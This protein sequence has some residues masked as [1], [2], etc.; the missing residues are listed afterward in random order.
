[1]DCT[2][3]KMTELSSQLMYVDAL[4]SLTQ[5]I[6]ALSV[7]CL[8]PLCPA[9]AFLRLS[10][11]SFCRIQSRDSYKQTLWWQKPTGGSTLSLLQTFPLTELG[12]SE[13]HKRWL[14]T[15]S[16]HAAATS[17]PAGA[18]A[19][20][21]TAPCT[22]QKLST[23]LCCGWRQRKSQHRD[24][25]LQGSGKFCN[26]IVWDIPSVWITDSKRTCVR[27]ELKKSA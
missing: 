5:A 6:A 23:A 15:L 8:L 26:N 25:N 22:P 18:A 13:W 21:L 4:H 3:R 9:R 20:G 14:F 7:S 24:S 27:W 17:N 16:P 1:M 10:R 11:N 12:P 2:S 19:V